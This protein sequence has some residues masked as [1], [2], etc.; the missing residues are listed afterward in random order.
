MIFDI[1]QSRMVKLSMIF[2]KHAYLGWFKKKKYQ[3][4]TSPDFKT[5]K[6]FDMR[7]KVH[8]LGKYIVLT[9]TYSIFSRFE[10]PK[11]DPSLPHDKFLPES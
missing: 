8:G 1:C 4:P 6:S 5:H 11:S 9:Y 3:P 2:Q 7:K 10:V